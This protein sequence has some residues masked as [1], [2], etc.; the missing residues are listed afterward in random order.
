MIGPGVLLVCVTWAMAAAIL[1]A[2]VSLVLTVPPARLA[3]A[4]VSREMVYALTFTLVSSLISAAL[5]MLVTMPV[6]YALSRVRFKGER[7][8]RTL[9]YLPMALPQIV[10]GLC[11]LLL[12]GAPPVVQVLQA[13]R[14]DLVFTRTGV[15]VAQFFTAF[16]YALRVLKSTFDSID[17]RL[18]FVSRSLGCS[19]WETFRRV[20]LPLAKVGIMASGSIAFARCVGAFGSVLVLG[21]GVR[22]HTE[23]LPVAIHLNLAYGNLE[24]AVAAGFLL[25]V[26]SSVGIYTVEIMEA[27]V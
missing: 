17:P 16:P 21:G 5:V 14:I 6:A 15:V 3:S 22:M 24:M 7:L 13:L 8:A 10:L 4:L 26:L 12:F 20:S 27:R 1:F 23:T 9:L 25:I 18:E 2:L 11:L 19:R